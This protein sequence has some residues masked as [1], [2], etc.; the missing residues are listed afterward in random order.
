MGQNFLDETIDGLAE[1]PNL[2]GVGLTQ[3]DFKT[4]TNR[5]GACRA[6]IQ[7]ECI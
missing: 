1:Q 7:G 2:P 4:L 5:A 3:N 6:Y